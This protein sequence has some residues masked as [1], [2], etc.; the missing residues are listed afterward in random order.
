[1]MLRTSVA[2]LGCGVA[3]LS[4]VSASRLGFWF[5]LALGGLAAL[6]SAVAVARLDKQSMA[7]LRRAVQALGEGARAHTPQ[8]G[9]QGRDEMARLAAD[10]VEMG[11]RLRAR[12]RASALER[13][14]LVAVLNGM[15]EGVLVLDRDART[16]LAN[17]RLRQL[18]GV[19][20]EVEGRSALELL[21]RAD[22]DQALA[23]AMHEG[24]ALQ[25]E[26][27]CDG[28]EP[29]VLEMHAR[30]FPADGEPSGVVAVFHDVTELRRLEGVRRDF[31]ANVSH[32]LRTPLTAIRGFAETLRGGDIS[33]AEQNRQLEI[34]QRHAERL[35]ALIDELL[36]FS[37]IEARREA[38]EAKPLNV[39]T[40]LRSIL[41]DLRPR[42]EAS[43][44][45]QQIEAPEA[46]FVL[47][48]RRALERVLLNLLDNALKYT[49]AGGAV[50]IGVRAQGEQVTIEVA[51]TGI[52]IPADELSRVFERFYRSDR[53]RALAPGGAGLGLAIVSHL[54]RDMDGEISV[55]STLGKGATFRLH[56]PRARQA[57]VELRI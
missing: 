3:L 31:V 49:G 26:V 46:L 1:M 29:R 10:I 11:A 9:L 15:A 4:A 42:F 8:P 34:I 17:Q 2:L 5:A 6:L 52:G 16:L 37:R 50:R 54:L 13:E 41:R 33:S 51:D 23:R 30:R 38:L 56:L 12:Q 40:L 20:R 43:A 47:A 18:F 25:I 27:R 53:A 24:D 48:D 19:F 44:M 36:E 28:P 14:R 21:R 35:S 57:G 7:R 32:E 22:I 45:T 55:H 39:A